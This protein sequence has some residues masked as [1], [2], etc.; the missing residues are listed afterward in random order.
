MTSASTAL[1]PSAH[2][3][4]APAPRWGR[5]A[6]GLLFLLLCARAGAAQLAIH[7]VGAMPLGQRASVDAVVEA[8][9]DSTLAAQVQG[10]VV[11]LAVKP[12]DS[13]K[14]GQELVRIDAR[15]ATQTAAASAAQVDAAQAGLLVARREYERQQQLFEKQYISQAALDRSSAQWQ[16]ARAQL[17]SLQAQAGAAV[18]QSGFFSVRAPYAGVVS[19]VPVALG[20]MALPGR[21]LVRL[22]DPSIWRVTATV[23]HT[24]APALAR[25]ATLELELP[26]L[27]SPRL[28]VPGTAAQVLPAVDAATHTAQVRIALPSPPPGIAP[29]M[30]A[31]L[32]LPAQGA[33]RLAVPQSA[34]VRRAEMTGVYVLDGL[35]RP[36]LRQVRVGRAE[37]DWVEILS[38][39]RPGDKVATDPQAA[40]R[41]R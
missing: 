32:W 29:G 1:F 17:Q 18:T 10:A 31:R 9:R 3:R 8:V 16:A 33:Q 28:A 35:G 11:L 15:A 7:E 22:H 6:A 14:A 19:E 41:E 38:G 13:V 26:A 36:L 2:S 37:G 20:D 25:A 12:G 39:V 5:L 23:P 24:V 27:P 34:L 4:L 40:A 30:F 21:A